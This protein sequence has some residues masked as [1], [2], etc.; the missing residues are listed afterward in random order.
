MR[1]TL[2]I[3]TR[4]ILTV[5]FVALALGIGSGLAVWTVRSIGQEVRQ[6]VA[7]DAQAA[8]ASTAAIGAALRTADSET[9]QRQ[10]DARLAQLASQI[11]GSGVALDNSLTLAYR[12]IAIAL[13][14]GLLLVAVAIRFFVYGPISAEAAT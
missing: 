2:K 3:K 11:E 4:L 13:F 12:S 7:N 6:R 9:A 5:G 14:G 10:A 8:R 1:S